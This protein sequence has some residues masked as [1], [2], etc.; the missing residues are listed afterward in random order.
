MLIII[1]VDLKKIS[2]KIL[3]FSWIHIGWNNREEFQL[4]DIKDKK[5]R[6]I[7]HFS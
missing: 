2:D 6:F 7:N 5:V 1:Q 3:H 4:P